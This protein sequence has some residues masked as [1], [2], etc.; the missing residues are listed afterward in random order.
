MSDPPKTPCV[1][2]ERLLSIRSLK[3]VSK[4]CNYFHS[5]PELLNI[6]SAKINY[7]NKLKNLY[8]PEDFNNGFICQHCIG[9]LKNYSIPSMSILNNLSVKNVP[10]EIKKLN[11]FE[12][13]LIQRAKAFQSVVKM[14]TVMNDNIPHRVKNDQV[15]GRTF[16]LPLPL[17]ETLQKICPDS[18][19]LLTNQE[20]FILVRSNPTK[21]KV[22]WENFVDIKKVWDALQWLKCWNPLYSK[23]IIPS[24]HE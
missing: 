1:S 6:N 7:W 10:E 2:C 12:K 24:N 11:D 19:P 13:M 17:E 20:L 18:D 8:E 22:M 5:L 16:H 15:K 9:N 4:V 23:I 14:G 3:L 21:G